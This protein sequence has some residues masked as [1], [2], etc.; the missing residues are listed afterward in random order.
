[1]SWTPPEHDRAR[2][3]REHLPV[4]GWRAAVGAIAARHGL[5]TAGARPFETGSDVVWS[6]GEHVVKLTA[7]VW[8]DEIEAEARCSRA[9]PGGCRSPRRRSSRA[10]SSRAGP[11]SS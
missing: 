3:L 2:E 11:T 5:P 9:S 8:R 6:L 7:P 10:A 4:D 1:M